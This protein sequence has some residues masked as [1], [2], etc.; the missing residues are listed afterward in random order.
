MTFIFILLFSTI[1]C[2]GLIG[3]ALLENIFR[4]IEDKN[5]VIYAAYII[6][7]CAIIISWAVFHVN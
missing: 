7:G 2:A 1:W 6:W 4:F 5:D 3:I